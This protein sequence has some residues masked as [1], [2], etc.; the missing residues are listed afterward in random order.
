MK[1]GL[2]FSFGRHPKWFLKNAEDVIIA[3]CVVMAVSE[4]GY[5]RLMAPTKTIFVR[6]IRSFLKNT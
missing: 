3:F 6:G 5:C 1:K 4:T 2:S